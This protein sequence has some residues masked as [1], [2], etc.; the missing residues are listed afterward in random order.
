M[1]VLV[2][3]EITDVEIGS[4]DEANQ[5]PTREE[6]ITQTSGVSPTKEGQNSRRC[7]CLSISIP[8]ILAVLCTVIGVKLAENGA[9]SIQNDK[10]EPSPAPTAISQQGDE[11]GNEFGPVVP[12]GSGPLKILTFVTETMGWSELSPGL[13]TVTPQWQA[14]TWLADYD[15]QELDVGDT[16]EFRERYALAVIYFALKGRDWS[17]DLYFLENTHACKWQVPGFDTESGRAIV[18]G[19]DCSCRPNDGDSCKDDTV[20]RLVFP[21]MGL[22]GT[23]PN[24]IKLLYDLDTFQFDSNEV[25]GPIPPILS[26]LPN[27]KTLIGH[28]NMLNGTLPENIGSSHLQYIDLHA[29]SIEGLLPTSMKDMAHLQTLNLVD[30]LFTGTLDPLMHME[31]LTGLLLDQN[32]FEGN[33]TNAFL[34]SLP[35]LQI[36]D[37]SENLLEGTLPSNLLNHENLII[38]DLSKNLFSGSLPQVTRPTVLQFLALQDNGLTGFFPE[39]FS[40]LV[41]LNHLDLST[42]GFSG[43]LPSTWKDLKRLEY[44]F[45]A[46]NPDLAPDVIP[47]F[48]AE[49]T[50]LVDLSLQST[51]R[52]GI[53]PEDLSNLTK[54]KYLDLASNS[55]QG[56]IPNAIAT[57]LSDLR[58][59]LLNHNQLDSDFPEEFSSLPHLELVLLHGNQLAGSLTHLC[60]AT[61]SRDVYIQSDCH[62]SSLGKVLCPCCDI[63][64]HSDPGQAQ[65]PQVE[66][67]SGQFYADLDPLWNNTFVRSEYD[68]EFGDHV[69][70]ATVVQ[71]D[72]ESSL[73]DDSDNDP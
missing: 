69:Y 7:I 22:Q 30:N 47:P 14:A 32:E 19:V 27:L 68:F 5:L 66:C 24:E 67:E 58:F 40:E 42:N 37:I 73:G 3:P 51:N 12:D 33:L 43:I 45:V 4:G 2:V 48:I 16:P 61:A 56:P 57:K 23:I 65:T 64:C 49:L 50:N 8:L 60:A 28:N 10:I 39:S 1:P 21:N 26:T 25:A 72:D 54:L 63:C 17:R 31:K 41:N 35:Q 15:G 62:A 34:D 13:D 59:L 29:N 9:A 46:F 71:K 38:I 53:I 44:F 52:I 18:M 70:S 20:K 11:E 36:L 55:L 6:Y